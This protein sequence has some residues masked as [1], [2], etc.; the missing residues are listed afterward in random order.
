[1]P[2]LWV[3]KRKGEE[4]DEYRKEI[5]NGEGEESRERLYTTFFGS[6]TYFIR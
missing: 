3:L 5:E 4:V 2:F 6:G 1:V